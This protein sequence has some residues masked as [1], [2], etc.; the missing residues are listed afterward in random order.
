M[1]PLASYLL[2][3][4][5]GAADRAVETWRASG[6]FDLKK[7]LKMSP[8]WAPILDDEKSIEFRKDTVNRFGNACSG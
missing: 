2:T 5:E 8:E 7:Y 6:A 4:P 1:K 3:E